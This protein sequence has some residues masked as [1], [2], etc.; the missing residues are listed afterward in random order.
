[1]RIGVFGGTFNP[2]HMGHL[3]VAEWIHDEF[4]LDRT[5]WMPAAQSPFKSEAE[6]ADAAHR[7]E[8][9]RCAVQGNPAFEVSD[10]EIRRDGTSFT[11]DTLRH[12]TRERPDDELFLIM[13]S[14]SLADFPRWKDATEIARL[15]DLLVFKRPSGVAPPTPAFLDGKVQFADAPLLEISSTQ[16]RERCSRQKTIRYLVPEVVRVYI[17]SEGLYTERA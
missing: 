3:L 2:P 4:G 7:L 1:M 14:D 5:I 16:I 6:S 17:D 9:V 13:G 15:V 12:L 10:F 8:M 11:I